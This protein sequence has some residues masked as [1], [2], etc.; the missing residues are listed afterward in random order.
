MPVTRCRAA[1]SD[2]SPNVTCTGSSLTPAPVPS[3]AAPPAPRPQPAPSD[4]GGVCRFHYSMLAWL[5]T[6]FTDTMNLTI[7]QAAQFSLLPPMAALAA[8]AVAGPLAD[9]LISKDWDV[10]VVRKT[11]QC[12]A[13][14]GPVACLAGASLTQDSYLPLGR[15]PPAP[16]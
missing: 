9:S 13:F 8:S 1:C 4:W 10:A 14:L 12:V 7:S 11:A 15:I 3:P 5:P 2:P 6:Y 16:D